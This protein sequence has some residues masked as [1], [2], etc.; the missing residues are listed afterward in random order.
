MYQ[1]YGEG[2][3]AD[4]PV[5]A[6]QKQ[7]PAKVSL[8]STGPVLSS[9]QTAKGPLSSASATPITPAESSLGVQNGSHTT[10]QAKEPAPSSSLLAY[11]DPNEDSSDED[12][13]DSEK[14]KKLSTSSTRPFLQ[15]EEDDE[16]DMNPTAAYVAAKLK[17][18]SLERK[19][20][21]TGKPGKKGTAK[22]KSKVGA[23]GVDPAAMQDYQRLDVRLKE[24]EYSLII[25]LCSTMSN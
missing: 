13:A 12:E 2:T 4:V 17:F 21:L 8:D 7:P 1:S 22:T 5:A 19:L 25:G 23:S 3:W 16:D 11:R 6:K 15:D 18:T 10:T 9:Q 20:G 14:K 24:R